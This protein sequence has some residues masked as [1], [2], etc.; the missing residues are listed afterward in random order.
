MILDGGRGPS[1]AI[2]TEVDPPKTILF[3]LGAVAS[4][5]IENYRS[6]DVLSKY[7]GEP[8]ATIFR[9]G[10]GG[11]HPVTISASPEFLP[12]L[13][14]ELN[15]SNALLL[16]DANVFKNWFAIQAD[17]RC[18]TIPMCFLQLSDLPQTAGPKNAV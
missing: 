13:V 5:T 12:S 8:A 3:G 10:G 17:F 15:I 1:R 14:F 11:G 18:F 9:L 16:F 4:Y 2:S 7:F 6:R